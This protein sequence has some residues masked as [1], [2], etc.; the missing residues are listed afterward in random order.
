MEERV[1]VRRE[2][3]VA[4]VELARPDKL[5]AMDAAMFG[6]IGDTFRTIGRDPAVR[7]I[8]V[9]GQG[10]HFTA[11]LDLDYASRQFP[12]AG[13]PGRAAEARL[14]HIEWLQD[15]FTAVEQARVPVVAAVHG[16]CVGAGVD[17]VAACDLRVAS[18]DSFFQIAEVDVAITADLGTLQRLSHLIPH[19]VLRE[20][21]YTGR[22]LGAEE[23][24]R[25]GLVNGLAADREAAL[26]AAMSLAQTIAAKS[27]LAIAGAKRSLNYSRGRPVEEGLRDVAQWNAATLVS[28]DL[29]EAIRARLG[30]TE[31]SFRPLD[32]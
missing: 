6:A 3:A 23:A 20:L 24:E 4:I 7:A 11:G 10:R 31:P 32:D 17:L 14:R 12:P 15:A 16:A 30:R 1:A 22:Q 25:L 27:P 29:Q 21:T 5:N 8:V 28:A 19:G 18:S 26:E 2:G 13:D 9:A